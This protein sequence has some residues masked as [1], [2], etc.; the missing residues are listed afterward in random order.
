MVVAAPLRTQASTT[1]WDRV[2]EEVHV[3][4][5]LRP[6]TYLSFLARAGHRAVLIVDE[7]RFV[8]SFV[9]CIDL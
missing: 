8:E 6:E 9:L 1:D 5:P 3:E 2:Q 7:K 4:H